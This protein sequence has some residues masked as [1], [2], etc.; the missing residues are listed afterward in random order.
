[1]RKRITVLM[2]CTGNSA[3]SQIAEGLLRHE[4]GEMFAVESAGVTPSFVRAEAI[5]VMR[6]IGIDISSQRSKSIDE[7]LAQPFDYVIT[8]CDN[9]NQN[10]PVFP[11]PTQ[12]IHW[13]VD[14]PAGVSGEYEVKLQA[15]RETRN[16]LQR[17]LLAFIERT[18]QTSAE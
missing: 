10:C 13:D 9:A 14:D 7:F 4:G 18:K 5:A 17:R 12:R 2:V 1:M 11:G 6:E 15:F 16:E 8:V 3:R